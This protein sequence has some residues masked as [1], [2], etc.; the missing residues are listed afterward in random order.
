VK[1]EKIRTRS[2]RRPKLPVLSIYGATRK[3]TTQMLSDVDTIVYD[4]RTSARGFYTVSAT[5]GL[6]LEAAGGAQAQDRRPRPPPP[7]SATTATARSPTK[8]SS[9]SPPTARSRSRTA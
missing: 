1:D 6:C 5:L 7:P 8:P 3:P 4:L 9:P 2:T